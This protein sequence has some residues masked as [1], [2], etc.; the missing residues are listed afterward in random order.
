MTTIYTIYNIYMS[1]LTYLV[2]IIS[3]NRYITR[4]HETCTSEN[5]LNNSISSDI[6]QYH[7]YYTCLHIY[8]KHIYNV[9]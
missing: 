7:T 5:D 3:Y 9:S 8:M 2:Y 6:I 1:I 4:Y